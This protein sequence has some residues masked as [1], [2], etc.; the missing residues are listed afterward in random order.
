MPHRILLVD[1]EPKILETHRKILESRYHVE[2]APDGPHGLSAL[3]KDEEFELIIAD[4]NMPGMDGIEFLSKAE[5]LSP[6]TTRMMLT[7]FGELDVAVKAVNEGHIFRF[8]T[9]PCEPETLIQVC[10]AGVRQYQ[11]VTTE[12]DLLDKTLHGGV[13]ILTELLALANPVA[14]SRAGRIRKYVNHI[15]SQL[16]LPDAWQYDLAATLSQ[17]GAITVPPA[18]WEKTISDVPLSDKEAK[19][20][21]AQP[22]IISALL[23]KVPRFETLAG[24]IEHQA[25]RFFPKSASGNLRAEDEILLGGHIL[26]AATEF[27]RLIARGKTQSDA[28]AELRSPANEFASGVLDALVSSGVASPERTIKAVSVHGLDTSMILDEDVISQD[29]LLLAPKG[30]NVTPL[31]M[32]RLGNFAHEVGVVEPIHVVVIS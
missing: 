15:V 26:R 29:G 7:A 11:L 5:G 19:M 21:A 10:A 25:D 16:G 23:S 1:D 17:I 20:L 6:F 24:M 22:R 30:Q 4:F 12:R 13:M 14:F 28:I 18:V 2:T 3:K 32:E 8:L 31:M 27:E 9:K